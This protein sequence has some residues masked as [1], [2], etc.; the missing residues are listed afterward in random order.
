MSDGARNTDP[1]TSHAASGAT[2]GRTSQKILLLRAYADA[3]AE[4]GKGLTNDEAGLR[5]GLADDPT[6][7]FW[8]RCSE[9]AQADYLAD[10]GEVRYGRSGRAQRVHRIT[11]KG[12]ERIGLRRFEGEEV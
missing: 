6:C 3:E 9:L 10:T 5:S 1:W 11:D 7:C 8:K 12:L 2:A 4:T